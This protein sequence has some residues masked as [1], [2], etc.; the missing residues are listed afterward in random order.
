MIR[1]T[2]L[3]LIAVCFLLSGCNKD[4]NTTDDTSPPLLIVET[5]DPVYTGGITAL[6]KGE[7]GVDFSF[8]I[9]QR[10]FVYGIEPQPTLDDNVIVVDG[11]T[12]VYSETVYGLSIN[13]N[14]YVRAF[15]IY[16]E[17]TI[18][19]ES[20][21]FT[22]TDFNYIFTK[23]F[24]WPTILHSPQNDLVYI[25]HKPLDATGGN[26]NY[27]ISAF[28]YTSA[29]IVAEYQS[30]AILNGELPHSIGNYNSQSELYIVDYNS[31]RFLNATLNE[32]AELTISN[33]AQITDV[34]LR[35]NLLFIATATTANSQG[36]LLVYNRDNLNLL[37][38]E[39]N[40]ST[41]DRMEIYPKSNS[42][43]L[44]CAAFTRATSGFNAYEVE[45]T[46]QGTVLT[47][48]GY[49]FLPA[50]GIR[51]L[52]SNDA[53]N[54]LIKGQYIFEK[55]DLNVFNAPIN[56]GLQPEDCRLNEDGS[57]LF[58]I[59]RNSLI[60]VYNTSN[61]SLQDS[62]QT[63]PEYTNRALFVDNGE[64]IILH[65][66]FNSNNPSQLFFT[67]YQL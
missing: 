36:A 61:F 30:G 45:F 50:G 35:N 1:I 16:S 33:D 15:A 4:S 37:S 20:K 25:F 52:R 38:S 49:S 44:I 7:I 47:T 55:G 2:V 40:F 3:S 64:A 62:I 21:Q 17:G 23:D 8:E 18:Y 63:R 28:N 57:L 27:T 65:W 11:T 19:G 59:Q 51:P 9:L 22:T 67:K 39:V 46:P 31:I 10:G 41:I 14:Y 48:Q 26:S 53:I 5:V 56:N 6:L 34:Q 29:Q 12:G 60:E 54:H 42:S 58:S 24:I 13:T 43:N 66:D 32:I